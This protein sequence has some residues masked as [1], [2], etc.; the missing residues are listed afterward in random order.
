MEHED[1]YLA[2]LEATDY[3]IEAL[4]KRVA[5]LEAGNER[6]RRENGELAAFWRGWPEEREALSQQVAELEAALKWAQRAY[7]IVKFANAIRPLGVNSLLEQAPARVAS[8]A[9][10][11]EGSTS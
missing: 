8:P 10:D 3:R 2:L 7:K 6:L 4:E 5:E 11:G 9:I 1:D